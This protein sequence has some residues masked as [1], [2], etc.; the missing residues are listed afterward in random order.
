M[1]FNIKLFH[2]ENFNE[3][4]EVSFDEFQTNEIKTKKRNIVKKTT[5]D[6]NKKVEDQKKSNESRQSKQSKLSL[7]FDKK[8]SDGS[9]GIKLK[10]SS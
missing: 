3:I 6:D 1:S 7:F 8:D 9:N 2:K 5:N 10:E 4:E